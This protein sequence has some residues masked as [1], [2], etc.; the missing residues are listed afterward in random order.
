MA[1]KPETQKTTTPEK[2]KPRA[3]D[4]FAADELAPLE[5]DL[6]GKI[7]VLRP[8]ILAEKFRKRRFLLWQAKGGFGCN[9]A[10]MGRAV[11]SVCVGDDESC[12]WNREDFSHIFTG[13]VEAVNV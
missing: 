12:R 11:M 6:V 10:A 1:K 5:G 7:L 3:E 8:H 9:P 4:Y 2:P 13:D